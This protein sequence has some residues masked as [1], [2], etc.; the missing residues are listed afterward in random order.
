M[1]GYHTELSTASSLLPPPSSLLPPPSLPQPSCFPTRSVSFKLEAGGM[2][3]AEGTTTEGLWGWGHGLLI[4]GQI[5]LLFAVIAAQV[6]LCY[7]RLLL[8]FVLHS[9]VLSLTHVLI[10]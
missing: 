8:L 7:Q 2:V 5:N 1:I 3:V 6:L 10:Y 9:F 4:A